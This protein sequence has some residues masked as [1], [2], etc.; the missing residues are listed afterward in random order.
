M[1][2]EKDARRFIFNGIEL[3]K[4]LMS[5]EIRQK[6]KGKILLNSEE[7]NQLRNTMCKVICQINSVANIDGKGRDD[8]EYQILVQ[9]ELILRRISRQ[10]SKAVRILA[11]NIRESFIKLRELFRKYEQNIEI[12]DPQLKNNEDLVEALT[13]FESSWEKGREYFLENEKCEAL[14]AFSNIIENLAEKYQQFNEALEC[15]EADIFIQIPSVLVLCKLDNDDKNICI[16]FLPNIKQEI[17]E[18]GLESEF[19]DWKIEQKERNKGYLYYNVIE[20][21]IVNMELN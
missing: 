10:Q 21:V 8:L 14:I 7:Y 12:V 3:E 20:K 1:V 5:I 9:A 2:I 17:K 11:Q 15:R 13:V 4:E 16:Q 19:R 18:I 6:M